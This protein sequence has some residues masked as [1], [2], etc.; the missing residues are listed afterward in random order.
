MSKRNTRLLTTIKPSGNGNRNLTSTF[1]EKALK[2]LSDEKLS[3][4]PNT[5]SVSK[6][7]RNTQHG[8]RKRLTPSIVKLGSKEITICMT[9]EQKFPDHTAV[10]NTFMSKVSHKSNEM[11]NESA[12][13]ASACTNAPQTSNSA[14][15]RSLRNTKGKSSSAVLDIQHSNVILRQCRVN[16]LKSIDIS[17]SNQDNQSC[18]ADGNDV[19][20]VE[21]IPQ[22]ISGS[23]KYKRNVEDNTME[24]EKTPMSTSE[25][26]KQNGT[27]NNSFEVGEMPQIRLK[28]CEVATVS[29]SISDMF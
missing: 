26:D 17:T 1:K 9:G 7:R 20:E 27:G 22:H 25:Q 29:S 11:Q 19:K 24:V 18:T 15:R 13:A 12:T 16:L 28:R 6:V 8:K 21:N 14:S 5:S 2:K 3:L 10:D 4:S 23:N